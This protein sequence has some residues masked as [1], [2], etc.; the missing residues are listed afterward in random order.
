V[1]VKF[2]SVF[3][4][5]ITS[6]KAKKM[7]QECKICGKPEHLLPAPPKLPKSGT[8]YDGRIIRMLEKPGGGRKFTHEEL[9]SARKTMP[10]TESIMTTR[11]LSNSIMSSRLGE[12]SWQGDYATS[13]FCVY[14]SDLADAR[15]PIGK[16]VTWIDPDSSHRRF[17]VPDIRHPWNPQIGL[18]AAHGVLV[19]SLAKLDYDTQ[20]S[21]VR[22]TSDFDPKTDVRVVDMA[23]NGNHHFTDAGGFPQRGYPVPLKPAKPGMSSLFPGMMEYP[24]YFLEYHSNALVAK[25]S[26]WTRSGFVPGAT[27][28]AGVMVLHAN[29][30]KYFFMTSA[31]WDHPMDVPLVSTEMGEKPLLPDPEPYKKPEK[32][33]FVMPDGSPYRMNPLP[34]DVE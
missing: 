3:Y 9:F 27:G 2:F 28:Y 1:G 25:C 4:V 17:E 10:L 30:F 8:L 24:P 13:D 14:R 33:K 31:T 29:K 19:F 18:R 12:I 22:V 7:Q 34:E 11:E 6:R 20:L 16:V 15:G 5:C 23:F 32:Y 21:M 26:L